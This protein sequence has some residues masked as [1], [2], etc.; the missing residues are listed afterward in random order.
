M[1]L[2]SVQRQMRV[3]HITPLHLAVYMGD[4]KMAD[5]LISNSA[6][7]EAKADDGRTAPQI[8]EELDNQEIVETNKTK[9][10]PNNSHLVHI[11][12]I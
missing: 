8:A 2:V 7:I 1:V 3:I 11:S 4:I 5:L 10:D 6:V 12:A 9:T